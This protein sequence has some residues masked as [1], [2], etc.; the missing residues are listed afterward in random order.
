MLAN[1]NRKK[2]KKK[3]KNRRRRKR[4]RRR[5]LNTSFQ[6]AT[7]LTS[8]YSMRASN[9]RKQLTYKLTNTNT[10]THMKLTD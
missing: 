3:K 9:K 8:Q 4:R 1:N 2:K 6:E 7:H 10:C 5:I